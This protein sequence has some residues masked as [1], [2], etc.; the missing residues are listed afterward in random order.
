MNNRVIVFLF[1]LFAPATGP[2]QLNLVGGLNIIRPT[3]RDP[4]W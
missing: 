1:G 2:P 3:K 4:S